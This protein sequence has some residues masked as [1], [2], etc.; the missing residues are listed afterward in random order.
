MK[1]LYLC[2]FKDNNLL[3]TVRIGSGGACSNAEKRDISLKLVGSL[4]FPVT[5]IS[6][7]E[8]VS[9]LSPQ[10]P[11]PV[12]FSWKKYLRLYFKNIHYFPCGYTNKE[13][14]RNFLNN[15]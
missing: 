9:F 15:S 13:L 7:V 3:T 10:V 5:L 2:K 11:L 4:G 12:P 1:F 6:S 14:E 8:L